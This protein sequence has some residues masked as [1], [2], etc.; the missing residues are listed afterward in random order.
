MFRMEDYDR[1]AEY[2][3]G[4]PSGKD[5]EQPNILAVTSAETNVVSG[6]KW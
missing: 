3:D 6:R 1:Y 2:L 5:V 4:K